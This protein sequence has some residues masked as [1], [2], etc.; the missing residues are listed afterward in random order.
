MTL[1]L[2]RAIY[3]SADAPTLTAR[4]TIRNAASN[5]VTLTF[6]SGQIYDLEIR[7]DKG[8]VVYRWS[9][10]KVFP[11]I[12]LDDVVDDEKDYWIEA[13]LA[14]LPTGNYVAQAW[15]AVDGPP[16]SYSASASFRIA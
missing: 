4:L 1:S 8:D 16:E 9:T 11:Q 3:A 15:L 7:N 12:V 14:G 10:G 13:P 6:L 2:D 5:P